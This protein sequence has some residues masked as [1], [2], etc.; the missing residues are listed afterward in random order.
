MC[1]NARKVKNLKVC[2]IGQFALNVGVINGGRGSFV[3]FFKKNVVWSVESTDQTFGWLRNNVGV[4]VEPRNCVEWRLLYAMRGGFAVYSGIQA[5]SLSDIESSSYDHMHVTG[6]LESV[7]VAVSI[8]Q[9]V[10]W[11]YEAASNCEG[12]RAGAR[13]DM[14]R[15]IQGCTSFF[16]V[17]SPV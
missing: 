4:R 17:C 7:P 15:R 1:K 5:R 8:N 3:L 13:H 16:D 11:A 9:M 2:P 10:S 12:R 6:N 14:R